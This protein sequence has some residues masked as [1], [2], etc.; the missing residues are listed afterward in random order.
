MT[1]KWN[2]FSTGSLPQEII[3]LLQKECNVAIFPE[4]RV[5]TKD[6]IVQEVKGR[7]AIMSSFGDKIDDE[8][9][10]A[11]RPT[12]KIIANCAVGY[13]NID[14]K[15]AARRGI[16]VTNT[17]G[18]SDHAV[19]DMAWG[20]LFAVARMIVDGDRYL[21]AG[22]YKG[23]DAR[24]LGL[25]VSGKILGIIGA[26]R[27]GYA[28]GKKAKGFDMK[29]LYNDIKRNEKFE[30]ETRAEYGSA[31]TIFRESDFISIHVPLNDRTK[32][33]VGEKELRMMKKTAILINTARGSIVDEKALVIALKEREIWGAGL[34][35]YEWEPEVSPELKEIPNVVL[36]AHQASCSVGNFYRLKKIA[37]ENVSAAYR[38][39]IPPNCVNL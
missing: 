5:M 20:L 28:F 30:Q 9:L 12:C 11:A 4:N 27:T 33:L 39:E 2:I 21:R 18:A 19:A 31:E 1:N 38:G 8:I 13:D 7:H 14:I 24:Y 22:I 36:T 35:V 26:G 6:E 10:E 25:D 23:S 16:Y 3:D 32:H 34:D 17:P 29:L 15:A 37:A